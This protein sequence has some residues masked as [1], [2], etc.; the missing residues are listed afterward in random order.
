MGRWWE[1]D[2]VEKCE[3]ELDIWAYA[4]DNHAIFGECK[5]TIDKVDAAVLDTLIIRSELFRYRHKYL[6]LFAK[7]C[8][9]N[10]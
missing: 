10:S 1:N 5:W 9:T 4:D 2:P 7:T 3:A 8:V 6:Y